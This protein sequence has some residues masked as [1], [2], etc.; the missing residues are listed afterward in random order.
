MVLVPSCYLRTEIEWTN[1]VIL[2]STLFYDRINES[3]KLFIHNMSFNV[4]F[5]ISEKLCLNVFPTSHLFQLD[6]QIK[7][8]PACLCWG[9][10]SQL[11]WEL[12]AANS[13]LIRSR[14]ASLK[15]MLLLDTVL[16]PLNW[17]YKDLF[18]LALLVPLQPWE[19]WQE[20]NRSPPSAWMALTVK[21]RN[22]DRDNFLFKTFTMWEFSIYQ[23]IKWIF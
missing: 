5:K 12:T 18:W 6:T 16:L 9:H 23:T 13:I 1:N 22:L 15:F 4:C 10:F 17:D 14:I 21:N 7:M 20:T 11:Q 2:I 3:P 19:A 8:I